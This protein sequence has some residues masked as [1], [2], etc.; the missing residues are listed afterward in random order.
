MK[1][2]QSERNKLVRPWTTALAF[3]VALVFPAWAD[4]ELERATLKGLPGV[5]VLVE[6]IDPDAERYG[7]APSALTKDIEQKLRQAGIRALTRP[8]LPAT[9]GKPYL[10]LRVYAVRGT[11]EAAGL[12][13]YSIGLEL[14]Q[15]VRLTR[16]S[17]VHSLAATWR[18]TEEVGMVE[19]ARL[20]SLRD[21][22]RDMVDQFISAYLA[23]NSKRRRSP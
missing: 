10:Y 2:L 8:E 11:G 16:V 1:E 18:A 12:Y 22:V 23:T 20:S 4:S 5:F 9:P 3:T 7:L 21:K 13:V 14:K 15:E 17:T 19:A 6:Q